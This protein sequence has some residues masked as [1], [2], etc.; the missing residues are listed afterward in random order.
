MKCGKP[1][2][3]S[4][5]IR[6]YAA[7]LPFRRLRDT[8]G[9]RDTLLTRKRPRVVTHKTRQKQNRHHVAEKALLSYS[10]AYVT[11]RSPVKN[12]VLGGCS[13]KHGPEIFAEGALSPQ[14]PISR[15]RQGQGTGCES[16]EGPGTEFFDKIGGGIKSVAQE[17]IIHT[18]RHTRELPYGA[19]YKYLRP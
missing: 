15:T 2:R 18:A 19:P 8:N 6:N 13:P 5:S 16:A 14:T 17:L 9:N 7:L 4:H 12:N 10:S 3:D 11:A 1:H